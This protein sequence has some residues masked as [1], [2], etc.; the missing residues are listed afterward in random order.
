MK[1]EKRYYYFSDRYK[2][3]YKLIEIMEN[4]KS[5]GIRRLNSQITKSD[6]IYR[7]Y[8]NMDSDNYDV[9]RATIVNYTITNLKITN[10]LFLFEFMIIKDRELVN[11]SRCEN[12]L[13]HTNSIIPN[14]SLKQ[15]ITASMENRIILCE[16]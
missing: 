8:L 2:Y 6:N 7:I 15:S 10:S 14:K 16:I 9:I 13:H 5:L 1:T 12:L 11:K 4:K 3:L